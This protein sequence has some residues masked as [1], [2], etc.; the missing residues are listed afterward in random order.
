MYS[1]PGPSRPP[2]LAVGLAWASRC[3]SASAGL[4]LGRKPTMH[5]RQWY[6]CYRKHTDHSMHGIQP[7]LVPVL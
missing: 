6:R 5:C 1:S 2:N 3:M 4:W 7:I